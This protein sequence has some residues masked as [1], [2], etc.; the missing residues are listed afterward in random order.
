MEY[1]DKGDL[2]QKIIEYKKLSIMLEETEIWKI[3]VQMVQGLK[4]LHDMKILHRDLKS[5]NVFL[6]SDGKVKLGDLNVSK[7]A[8]KGLGYTQTG[9]PYYASPE[10]WKDQPY[11]NKSDIWS[12][13]CVLYEM[14]ALRP[15]FRAENMEGL[16][17]KVIKGVY[18]KISDRYSKDLR[19]IIELLL[20]V[21]H[22]KRPNC[23]NFYLIIEQLLKNNIVLK[24][25]EFFK[26]KCEEIV[27][28]TLL[29]TIKIPKNMS[30]LGEKLPKS[31]YDNIHHLKISFNYEE[32]IKRKIFRENDK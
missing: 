20:Q 10:V 13:G 18:G 25:I 5:A 16:Y 15:P 9:T 1:A 26:N 28:P 30:Y 21:S 14:A 6:Y 32:Y 27:E 29:Q 8:R 22:E 2:H 19:D 23:S 7:V 3:F 17:N 31:N 11:N 4:A 12:L 24:R